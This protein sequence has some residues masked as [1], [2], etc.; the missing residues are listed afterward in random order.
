MP[1]KPPGFFRRIVIAIE[2]FLKWILFSIVHIVVHSRVMTAVSLDQCKAILVVRQHNQIGDLLCATPLFRA[3]REAY[4]EAHITVL[5]RPLTAEVLRGTDLIDE[6]LVFDKQA[7]WRNPG[8]VLGFL[9]LLWKRK[10]DLVL[11]PVTVSLSTTSDFLAWLSRS[12]TRIGPA[13]LNGVR[14]LTH[15]MHNVRVPLDWRD[16]P[17][18]HQTARNLAIVKP[19]ALDKTSRELV[20]SLSAEE[21]EKGRKM[22]T[23]AAGNH[24]M[25]IG[26]H[27]GAAKAANMW[28]ALRFAELANRCAEIL[29]AFL[30]ITAG[31]HD[32]L[33]L[34][35]MTINVPNDKLVLKNYPLR[36]VA[37]AIRCCA[38][39]VTNDTGIMHLAAAVGTP[40]LSLFGPTDPAQ[41]APPG[42]RHRF[43]VGKNGDI[44]S[45]TV[46]KVWEA[47]N[48][49]LRAA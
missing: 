37:A 22:V 38:V 18:T 5:L 49:M 16:E 12:R 36:E 39:F 44:S 9:R 13:S 3:L 19:L 27:P 32:D 21:R 41:W 20:L 6:I 2:R 1:Y 7:Y 34:H 45:I 14:N 25:V 30:L 4:P 28:D 29:D 10:Y 26:F 31:P 11:V 43:I 46:D 24:R 35:E 48:K 15:Y 17:L 8:R 42:E 23:E 33:P 40:T 47:L